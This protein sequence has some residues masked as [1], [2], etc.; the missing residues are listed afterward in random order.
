M[1]L[2]SSKRSPTRRRCVAIVRIY[3]RRRRIETVGSMCPPSRIP[4]SFAPSEFIQFRLESALSPGQLDDHCARLWRRSCTTRDCTRRRCVVIVRG[5]E[6]ETR[7]IVGHNLNLRIYPRRQLNRGR[8]NLVSVRVWDTETGIGK[9]ALP[10]RVDCNANPRTNHFSNPPPPTPVAERP[11]GAPT[12]S[13]SRAYIIA[14]CSAIV[15]MATPA[16]SARPLRSSSDPRPSSQI[17]EP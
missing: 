5:L 8:W 17:V 7:T 13:W 2:A 10:R 4:V 16:V 12:A 11:A 15:V 9:A 3:L 14:S 6:S 1:S